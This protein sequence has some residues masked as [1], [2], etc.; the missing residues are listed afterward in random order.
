MESI[1]SNRPYRRLNMR[2]YQFYV[3][4]GREEP[5]LIGILPERRKDRRRVTW[6]SIMKWGLLAAGRYVNPE[7]VYFVEVELQSEG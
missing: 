2:A 3:T 7:N 5:D 6:E 4:D 1:V